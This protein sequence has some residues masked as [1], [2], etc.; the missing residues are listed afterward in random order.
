MRAVSKRRDEWRKLYEEFPDR[1][2]WGTDTVVTARKEKTPDW[3]KQM[4]NSYF[5]LFRDAEFELPT[6]NKDYH[7]QKV[8]KLPGMKLPP[9]LLKK[10]YQDN[11]H[12]LFKLDHKHPA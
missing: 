12:K 9:E 8:D 1:L 7:L 3:I 6:F 2:L 11:P 4:A 5:G 10:I